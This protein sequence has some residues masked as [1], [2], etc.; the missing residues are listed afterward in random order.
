MNN[1][2]EL[3]KLRS[4]ILIIFAIAIIIAI[5]LTFLSLMKDDIFESDVSATSEYILADN[6]TAN[7]LT[8]TSSKSLTAIAKNTTWLDFDGIDNYVFIQDNNYKT[9]SYWVNDS[10]N[11]WI[12]V[13]NTS[14]ILY[15]NGDEV[16]SL[17]LNSIKQ[18]STGWYIGENS[19]G[20][21]DGNIDEVTFYNDTINE[22]IVDEVYINGR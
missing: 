18:N 16:S 6:G 21:F 13:V 14:D 11:D 3:N 4:T 20:Y 1:K 2:A 9:I 22:T 15:E 8:Q 12:H 5:V 7:T 10:S 17:T 19:T